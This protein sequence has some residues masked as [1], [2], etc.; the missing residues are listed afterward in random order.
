LTVT[1]SPILTSIKF[2]S[3]SKRQ[4]SPPDILASKRTLTLRSRTC[5][6]PALATCG[7]PPNPVVRQN[8]L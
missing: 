3:G 6:G 7:V 2:C 1:T 8:Q 5:A 4:G